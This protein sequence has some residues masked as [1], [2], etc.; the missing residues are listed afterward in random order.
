VKSENVK[1]FLKDIVHPDMSVRDPATHALPKLL[2]TSH[3]QLVPF[4]LSDLFDI[5]TRNN[6]VRLND[7]V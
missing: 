4:I 2:E 5:Y 1:D 6:K 7:C 3:P